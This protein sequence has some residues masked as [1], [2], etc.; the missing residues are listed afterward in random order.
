MSLMP[1]VR[2]E[3]DNWEPTPRY[4]VYTGSGGTVEICCKK[5]SGSGRF[6]ISG[7]DVCSTKN[8]KTA[9]ILRFGVF[10]L[11]MLLNCKI[12]FEVHRKPPLRCQISSC[13]TDNVN[14]H[15]N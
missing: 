4:S 6:E 1:R 2:W 9:V 12:V 11:E 5:L 3:C 8:H 7:L 10:C 15:V 13:R 14:E